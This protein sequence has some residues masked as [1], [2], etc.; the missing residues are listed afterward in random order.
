MVKNVCKYLWGVGN[1]SVCK[2]GKECMQVFEDNIRICKCGKEC[3]QVFEGN[4]SV[5]KCGKE[6]MLS[7]FG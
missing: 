3:M 5:C 6:C 1:I 7:I 2:C 4:I